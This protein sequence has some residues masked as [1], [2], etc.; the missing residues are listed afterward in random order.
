MS[1]SNGFNR[2]RFLSLCSSVATLVATRAEALI[3]PTDPVRRRNRVLLADRW[4]QPIPAASLT[5][6][7]TYL[8]HY[9]YISTPCYLLDLGSPAES[10]VELKTEQGE[11]YRWQGG[12]GPR[13]SLV[14]FAAICAH[15]MTHPVK[16]VS[17]INYR[18]EEHPFTDLAQTQRVQ[19]QVIHCCSEHSVYDVR[20]GCEVLGGPAP[21]PLAAIALEH[22]PKTDALYAIGTYGGELF[23]AY[24][25][26]FADRL[27][28]EYATDQIHREVESATQL[29]PLESYCRNRVLC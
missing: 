10:G 23:D 21:Q 6:G 17:F 26:K 3:R 1:I 27:I 5:V 16:A 28:L 4:K 2:R 24:I 25:E 9:P 11:S 29:H 7:Q 19:A 8:F 18:H 20:R 14:A 22:D 12:V 15:K 13:R